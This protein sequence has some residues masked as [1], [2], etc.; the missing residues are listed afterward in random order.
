MPVQTLAGFQINPGGRD[1][2]IGVL[3]ETKA[4]I[5]AAGGSVRVA[6]LSAGTLSGAIVVTTTHDSWE[7]L[8]QYTEATAANPPV[9]PVRD[10]LNAPNPPASLIGIFHRNELMARDSAPADETFL[11]GLSFDVTGNRAEV[12]T[13]LGGTRDA[14]EALGSSSRVWG[15][16]TGE[17]QGRITIVSA[18]DGPASYWRFRAALEQQAAAGTTLPVASVIEHVQGA[19]IVHTTAIDL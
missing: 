6:T 12:V 14:F 18:F 4:A 16:A 7:A 13:A 17:N 10:A 11:S 5:E 8:A 3:G 9:A 15:I 1:A 2:M 19:G